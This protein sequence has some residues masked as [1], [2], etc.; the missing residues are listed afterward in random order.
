VLAASAGAAAAADEP[1]APDCTTLIPLLQNDPSSIHDGAPLLSVSAVVADQASS[2]AARVCTGVGHYRD[3][4]LP[5]TYTA[6]WRPANQAFDIE[7]HAATDDEAASRA[8]SLRA[9]YHPKGQDGTFS[10]LD[11][12]SGCTDPDYRDLATQELRLG[13]SFRDSFYREPDADILDIF[14]NGIG[15]GLLSNCIATVGTGTDKGEIFIGTNWT[16]NGGDRRI[17]FYVFDAGP[18]GFKLKDRLWQLDGK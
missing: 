11:T 9:L 6:R 10:L 4:D 16:G 5:V 1:M 13:I 2:D 15:S 12:G 8:E 14:A 18:E 3:S 17:Q 7:M